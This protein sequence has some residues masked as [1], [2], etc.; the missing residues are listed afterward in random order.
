M[1]LES[2]TRNTAL[3]M[4]ARELRIRKQNRVLLNLI[5]GFILV[6][7]VEAYVFSPLPGL[8]SRHVVGASSA[9]FW[10]AFSALPAVF[11]LSQAF[12]HLR[13]LKRYF[14]HHRRNRRAAIF[15]PI[16][17]FVALTL[18]LTLLLPLAPVHF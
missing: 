9:L 4:E 11:L 7:L 6:I 16:I 8:I 12:L 1:D 14:P 15:T 2:E 5:W 13:V 10:P 18:L 17:S 3:N